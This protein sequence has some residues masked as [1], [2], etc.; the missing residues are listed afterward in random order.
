MCLFLPVG[1]LMVAVC[2]IGKCSGLFTSELKASYQYKKYIRF[3]SRP[4]LGQMEGHIFSR[5]FFHPK[6]FLGLSFLLEELQFV[7]FVAPS[8]GLIISFLSSKIFV[9][10]KFRSPR[11]FGFRDFKLIQVH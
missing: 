11:I 10:L 6:T 5:R 1:D 2:K 9:R 3:E 4:W 7:D 8:A